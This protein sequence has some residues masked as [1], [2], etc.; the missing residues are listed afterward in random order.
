MNLYVLVTRGIKS[1]VRFSNLIELNRT[2]N[3]DVVQSSYEIELTKN[4]CESNQVR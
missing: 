2:I 4:K 1:N 3:F